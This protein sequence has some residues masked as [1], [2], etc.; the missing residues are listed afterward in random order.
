M[1]MIVAL[2]IKEPVP[3]RFE[4]VASCGSI[5]ANG[6]A[7]SAAIAASRAV[8]NLVLY[9]D[10]ANPPSPP[11]ESVPEAAGKIYYITA[12]RRKHQKCK[13]LQTIAVLED[14]EIWEVA[15]EDDETGHERAK[16]LAATKPVPRE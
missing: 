8:Q 1:E 4:A 13:Y 3:K 7:S 12:G 16:F 5:S 6:N 14:T 2:V 15:Y 9:S 11:P 10:S